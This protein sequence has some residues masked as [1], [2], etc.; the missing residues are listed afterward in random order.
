MD[1]DIGFRRHRCAD[2]KIIFLISLA[3]ETKALFGGLFLYAL[4]FDKNKDFRIALV[5]FVA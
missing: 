5:D 2:T 4:R 3:K 1:D